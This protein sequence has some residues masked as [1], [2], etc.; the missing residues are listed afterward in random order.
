MLTPKEKPPATMR[1]YAE[2]EHGS[3]IVLQM[4]SFRGYGKRRFKTMFEEA[5]N[6]LACLDRPPVYYRTMLYLLNVLDPVQFRRISGRE[7]TE[8]IGIS[9]SSAERALAMLEA[10]Q[11]IFCKGKSGAKARRLNNQVCWASKAERFASAV[12]DLEVIDSRGR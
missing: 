4:R 2:D 10:D 8:A 6:R 5:M 1:L 9:M 7:I 11:V 12:A 3:T